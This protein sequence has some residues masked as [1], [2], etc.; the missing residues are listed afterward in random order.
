MRAGAVLWL[1]PGVRLTGNS[2]E[3]L[4]GAEGWGDLALRSGGVLTW[5]L[6]TPASL[7]SA[8]LTH[9]N[10]FAFFHTKKQHYDFQLVG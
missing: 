5:P 8:A 9:P 2:N 7:P 4:T 1:D 3:G 10:M 6:L